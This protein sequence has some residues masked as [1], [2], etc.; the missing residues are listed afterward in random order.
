MGLSV[1]DGTRRRAGGAG[2][3][4]GWGALA[5]ATARRGLR[6]RRLP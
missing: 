6:Y 3:G 5:K 4:L 2:D 1:H